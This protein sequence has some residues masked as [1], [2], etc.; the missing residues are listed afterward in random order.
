MAEIKSKLD[1][2]SAEFHASVNVMVTAIEEFRSI[3]RQVSEAAAAKAPRYVE[4]GFVAPRDRLTMLLDHGADFLE[5][6]TLCG[7]RQE[8]DTD[9]SAAGGSCISGIGYIDGVRCMVMVDDF[10]TKGGSITP[11]GSEKRQRML[12]IADENKLPVIVLAQSDLG[13]T[14]H[15]AMADMSGQFT[16]ELFISTYQGDMIEINADSLSDVEVSRTHQ[17]CDP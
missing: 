4:R 13:K 2:S 5:L 14:E 3:E 17:T 7:Y 15:V 10:L 11:L 8:G 9:G 6:S 16:L 1:T 12:Q